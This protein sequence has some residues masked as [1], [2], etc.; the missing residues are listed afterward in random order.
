M[1]IVDIKTTAFSYQRKDAMMDS[2]CMTSMRGFLLVT[3]ETDAGITGYGEAACYGGSLPAV[4]ALIEKELKPVLIGVRAKVAGKLENADALILHGQL[5]HHAVAV[6]AAAVVHHH[7]FHVKVH[8]VKDFLLD[9][10]VQRRQVFSV[11]VDGDD[12]G[13]LRHPYSPL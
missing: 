11:V 7:D 4:K 2:F 12:D 1:K 8:L 6:V 5:Q 10:G 3:V 9:V 13:H